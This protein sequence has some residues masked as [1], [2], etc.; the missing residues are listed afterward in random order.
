MFYITDY[1]TLIGYNSNENKPTEF[2]DL[3]SVKD[4]ITKELLNDS[5]TTVL[6]SEHSKILGKDFICYE[7]SRQQEDKYNTLFCIMLVVGDER[8]LTLGLLEFYKKGVT[9]YHIYNEYLTVEFAQMC[10]E[11]FDS[12]VLE[13]NKC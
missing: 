7:F 2:S 13:V 11:M 5:E 8:H 10:K 6:L 12:I 4:V 3:N 1:L 9:N